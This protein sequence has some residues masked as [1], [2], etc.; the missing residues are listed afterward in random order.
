[1]EVKAKE[2][3]KPIVEVIESFIDKG[4]KPEDF[5][6]GSK[7]QKT[8]LLLHQALPEVPKFVIESLSGIRAHYRARQLN[9]KILFMYQGWLWSYFIKATS[10]RGY[11]LYA[12]T[13]NDKK[14][15]LRWKA[16]GLYGI[17]TDYPDQFNNQQ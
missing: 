16:Y 7:S 15:A 2:P 3:T 14:K 6:L 5:F 11:K 9:T 12:Y 13:L 4:W 10:S 17:V 1:M 8:L